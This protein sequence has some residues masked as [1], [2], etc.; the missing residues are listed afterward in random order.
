MQ[1]AE[2]EKRRAM[3]DDLNRYPRRDIPAPDE[4]ALVRG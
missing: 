1:Q 4:V 2:A 3:A